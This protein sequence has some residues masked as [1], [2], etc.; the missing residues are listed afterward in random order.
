MLKNH[1]RC[2]AAVGAA[3]T[4]AAAAVPGAAA[5]AAVAGPQQPLAA[6]T[7]ALPKITI[8]MNGEKITVSGALQSGGVE[9]ESRV[10]GEPQGTRR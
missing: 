9:I 8:T 6:R 1:K 5:H 10:T 7:A 4:A 2:L 3:V